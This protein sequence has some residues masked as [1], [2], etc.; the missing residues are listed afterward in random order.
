MSIAKKILVFFIPT[1]AITAFIYV[2]YKTVYP[3]RPISHDP[4]LPYENFIN[5]A[6]LR[7][8]N[9][10][11]TE[12]SV[13]TFDREIRGKPDSLY[14]K[15]FC[16]EREALVKKRLAEG[17]KIQDLEHAKETRRAKVREHCAPYIEIPVRQ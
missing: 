17:A 7:L 1:I 6:H 9:L 3:N 10:A 12:Q 5:D 4:P 14:L 15:D 11:R 16:I 13:Q 8:L 2:Q